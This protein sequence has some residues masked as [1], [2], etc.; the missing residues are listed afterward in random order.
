LKTE[1]YSKSRKAVRYVVFMFVILSFFLSFIIDYIL[2][3]IAYHPPKGGLSPVWLTN[4][5]KWIFLSFFLLSAGNPRSWGLLFLLVY[6]K[7]FP[8]DETR[9]RFSCRMARKVFF[10]I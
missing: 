4:A 5:A 3:H 6:R 1:S 2:S 7:I 9:E 8:H 10:H